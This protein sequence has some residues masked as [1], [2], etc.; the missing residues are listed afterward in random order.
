M[1][2]AL[3]LASFSA[4]AFAQDEEVAAEEGA[5][6]EG[7]PTLIS[8]KSSVGW[9][10]GRARQLYGYEGSDAVYWST[11][12]G[13]KMNLAIDLPIIPIEVVNIDAEETG[14]LARIPLVALE[15]EFGTGYH[16]STGGT[17][18]DPI[19]NSVFVT[20]KR[21]TSY[22]PVTI[23][24]NARS[25]FGE[26]MP[27][28]Y[29]GAGGGIALV[30]IYEERVTPSNAPAFKRKMTPPVPFA[31]YGALGFEIP[32]SYSAD[33]GNSFFDLFAE[34]R[35]T[36]M[37]SYVYEHQVI[38]EGGGT[39]TVDTRTDNTQIYLRDTQRSASNVALNLGFKINIY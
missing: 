30:G 22:I 2:L 39:T 20:T 8:I 31:L 3:L 16:L 24:L 21:T 15:A 19:S 37:S 28:V 27:S 11:G 25:S 26:G 18:N 38:S 36:E 12:Q 6:E 1:V 32:V 17:T 4:T 34:L 23:G 29:L 14:G 7:Y 33:D 13:V 35:L 5:S 9:G 10:M